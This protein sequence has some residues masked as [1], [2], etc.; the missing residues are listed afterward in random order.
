MSQ[1][2]RARASAPKNA[3][4]HDAP[5]SRRSRRASGIVTRVRDEVERVLAE[6]IRPLL[7]ADG[8]EIDLDSIDESSS[9]IEIVFR[10][11][12]AYRGCPGTPLV[13]R[14]VIV[15]ALTKA[16]GRDV[17]VRLVPRATP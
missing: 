11:G 7:E 2:P 15:P 16:L 1:R 10:I 14:S 12:G 6:V 4:A 9:P 3:T 17:R 8:G 13:Q 5:K